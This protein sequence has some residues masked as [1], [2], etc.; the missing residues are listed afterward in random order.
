MEEQR[1]GRFL[2]AAEPR[3]VQLARSLLRAAVQSDTFPWLPRPREEIVIIVAP[4]RRRFRELAGAGSP[5]Y[6]SAIAQ[7]ALRRV[8]MQGSRAGS[9]AGDPFQAL[10]HELAHLALHERLGD[11][12]PRWFHEGYASVAAGEWGREEV[13]ATNVLLAWRGMP[14]L[15]SLERRFAGGAAQASAAYALAHRAVVEL[16]A[17]DTRHG[18]SLF[19]D[20]W[21]ASGELDA[22]IRQAFGMTQSEFEKRWQSRTKRRYGA[23][24]LFTDLTLAALVLLFI[25]TP[26]YIARRRRDRERLERM[27][28]AEAEAERREREAAIEE[29]IRSTTP[30]STDD[31]AGAHDQ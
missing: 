3:D 13:L 22:A 16:A 14:S 4:D 2:V 6:G 10:R 28:R 21:R 25:I 27:E 18:L 12:P 8:V 5:E 24:A 29:L 20:Y 17:L 9:D 11:V 26:L 1:A 15:D 31:R 30:P 7:P 23:L 19:F